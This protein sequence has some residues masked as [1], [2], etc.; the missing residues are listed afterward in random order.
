M[1]SEKAIGLIEKV[2]RRRGKMRKKLAIILPSVC[3]GLALIVLIG[4][5][6]TGYFVEWGPFAEMANLRFEKLAGND[7]KYAVERVEP[8]SGSPLSGKHIL[9]L[10]S[11][12]TYGSASLQTTFAEYIAKRN[13][14]TFVKEAVSGTTLVDE[15]IGSYISRLRKLNKEEKFDLFICQLSTNDATQKKAL[16]NVTAQG[17]TQFDTHTVCGAIE[18]IICYVRETWNC[19]VLFY[20][21][22]Y[23]ESAEYTAMVEALYSIREKYGIGVIDLY[24]DKDFNNITAEERALWMS[25]AIHPTRAGYLEWWTPAMEQSLYAFWNEINGVNK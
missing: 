1:R 17:T 8:L 22:A 4:L 25:D 5:M 20:T 16:G 10:G 24:T 7:E 13:N 3:V 23:Y 18:F 11:S 14:A 15:G 6:C 9:F 19:P 21:N 12:V 2:I